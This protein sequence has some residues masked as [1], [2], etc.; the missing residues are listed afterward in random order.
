[1]IKTIQSMM[2]GSLSGS[3]T[4]DQACKTHGK[5]T[6]LLMNRGEYGP[7]WTE[8]PGCTLD[9]RDEEGK[10]DSLRIVRERKHLILKNLKAIHLPEK[11]IDAK[12]DDLKPESKEHERNI[13]ICRRFARNF[14]RALS[15]GSCLVMYGNPGTG[16]THLA[17]SIANE[18]I[19]RDY[20]V[21]SVDA[22][23]LLEEIK[24]NCNFK[25]D[26]TEHD[27]ILEYS[28]P[29][30]LII[31]ELNASILKDAKNLDRIFSLINR[32]YNKVKC[33]ILISNASF[34]K[35]EVKLKD[36]MCPRTRDRIIDNGGIMM[37]FSHESWRRNNSQPTFMN[38]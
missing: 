25:N 5:Y 9:A 6:S 22:D 35:G 38:D 12:F 23:S 3:K 36:L 20:A 13:D 26:S 8:C 33:T 1:M 34:K 19:E 18:I 11:Y 15:A 16:K 32:R 10:Q 37:P 14:D 4:K 31:D 28:N 29:D 17:F 21:A 2:T 30:L 7:G 24:M 27:K